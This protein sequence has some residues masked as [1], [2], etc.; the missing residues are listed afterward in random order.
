MKQ[1]V[2]MAFL[3]ETFIYSL[4]IF[5]YQLFLLNIS[6]SY[7]ST[8]IKMR[9]LATERKQKPPCM[10][11]QLKRQYVKRRMEAAICPWPLAYKQSLVG[12]G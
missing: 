11:I 12:K 6:L 9:H 5:F 4:C 3:L 1:F 10:A 7:R 2:V 8:I